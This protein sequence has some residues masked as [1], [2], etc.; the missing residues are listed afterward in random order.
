MGDRPPMIIPGWGRLSSARW[1]I[2]VLARWAIRRAASG[3][4]VWRRDVYHVCIVCWQRLGGDGGNTLIWRVACTVQSAFTTKTQSHK[5]T[6]GQGRW[7]TGAVCGGRGKG[8]GSPEGLSCFGCSSEEERLKS[9]LQGACRRL[10][11]LLR[12]VEKPVFLK[13]KRCC[14]VNRVRRRRASH[15]CAA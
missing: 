9:S 5:D 13:P 3:V 11:S 1:L 2:L 14:L 12:R 15:S 8:V 7:A 6:K 4:A 10:E